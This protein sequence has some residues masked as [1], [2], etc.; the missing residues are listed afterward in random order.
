M[1]PHGHSDEAPDVPG[2]MTDEE[3]AKLERATGREFDRLFLSMM[4][5][6]H[7]GAVQLAQHETRSGASAEAKRVAQNVITTQSAEMREMKQL[8]TEV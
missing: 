6:H 8:L 4:I 5:R 1:P 2:M 7:Q 3:M